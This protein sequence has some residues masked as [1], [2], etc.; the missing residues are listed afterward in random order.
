MI[1]LKIFFVSLAC[2]VIP[3]SLVTSNITYLTNS[4][5]LYSYNW[6]RNDISI[7]TG[8][9]IEQ[10]N[11]GSEQIKT[12]FI[13]DQE[14]LDLIIKDGTSQWSLYNEREISHMIDVKYIMKTVYINAFIFT[15]LLILTFISTVFIFR[16]ESFDILTTS[17]KISS[18]IFGLFVIILI[19]ASLTDF[20]WLFTQFHLIS[21]SNDLWI[22]DPRTDYLIMMFPER[23]FLE[24]TLMIGF[25][26]LIEY[27]GLYTGSRL[28]K[29]RFSH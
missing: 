12:Y 26:T 2:V 1:K 20:T 17:I 5:W 8:L 15:F 21:F 16:R 19:V 3:I 24:T 28:C 23:F 27:A 29:I 14:K 6:W 9:S 10:L 7:N 11:N 4:D 25:L 18:F 22:L 13:N